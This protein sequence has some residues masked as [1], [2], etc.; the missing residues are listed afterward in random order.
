MRKII[1]LV[2]VIFSVFLLVGCGNAFNSTN[3]SSTS[4]VDTDQYNI[5]LLAQN[6][7]YSGTYEE[8]LESIRG[9]QIELLLNSENKIVWK[10]SKEPDSSY[11][12]LLD[13][14]KL[15]G[16]TGESGLSAY[17]IYKKYYDYQKSEKEWID[18]LVNGRLKQ[19]GENNGGKVFH[20]YAFNKEFQGFFNTY[21]SDEK[22]IFQQIAADLKSQKITTSEANAMKPTQVHLDGKLVKWTIDDYLYQESL[23]NALQANKSASGDDKVDLFLVEPDYIVKYTNSEYTNDITKIGVTD[24]SNVYNYTKEAASDSNGVI[25]GVCFQCCPGGVIYRRSIAKDVLGTDDPTLVQ[26]AINDWFKFDSVA[27]QMKAKDYY[28]VA[29]YAETYQAFYNNVTKPW[30]DKDNKLQIDDQITAWLNQTEKYVQNGYTLSNCPGIWDL[31]CNNQMSKA[32]KT[33]CYFG[34]AWY[35]NDC[36]TEAYDEESGCFGDW[37]LCEGPA[38]YFWGGTWML[39]AKDS[40]ND[41]LVGKVMDAFINDE[42]LCYNLVTK[43]EQFCNNQKVN[44]KVSKEYD[45]KKIGNDF[46]GGQND[47]AIS[48]EIAK[49]IKFQNVT[50]YD[51]QCNN[52]IQNCFRK[53]LIGDVDKDTAL[54]N[55]KNYIKNNVSNVLVS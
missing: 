52:G 49:K 54:L 11:R 43:E 5:Y 32:G 29:S 21:L 20:I 19:N 3:D 51:L 30:V 10:Y 31:D 25:K 17:E 23:D 15:K 24:F 50:I 48:L 6:S 35:Y 14:S 9:D 1:Y 26:E 4:N 39:A 44:A 8:W 40:D 13:V 22:A 53:Y 12:V 41:H 46:L 33:F 27:A 18:D 37:A 2:S 28:M 45:E 16:D 7:G 38:P 34:P 55:F 47:L 36:M 42:D